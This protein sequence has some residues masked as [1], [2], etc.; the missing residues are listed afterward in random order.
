[1][2]VSIDDMILQR[3]YQDCGSVTK[4]WIKKVAQMFPIV[5]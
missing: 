4:N 3:K 2:K 5:A 1:M